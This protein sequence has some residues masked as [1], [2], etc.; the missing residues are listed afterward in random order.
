MLACGA[1][2]KR[3][4]WIGS[5]DAAGV[6]TS[7]FRTRTAAETALTQAI[8]EPKGRLLIGFDFPMGYP[9]GF[10]ARL[11]GT[12][13]ARAVWRWL[14]AR[15]SDGPKNA[16]NRFEVAA[17]INAASAISTLSTSAALGIDAVAK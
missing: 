12:P 3:W 14:A 4:I 1:S 17:A 5:A 16:N 2:F 11:T 13:Q 15:I 10:A 7:Y 6:E 9:T 8:L